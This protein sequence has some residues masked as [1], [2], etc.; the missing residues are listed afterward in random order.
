VDESNGM[1]LIDYLMDLGDFRGILVDEC[2]NCGI[3]VS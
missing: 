1:P 3:V 2:L